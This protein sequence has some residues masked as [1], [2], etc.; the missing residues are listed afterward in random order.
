KPDPTRGIEPNENYAR[1]LLQ[2]FS[3]GTVKLNLDGTPQL[4]G[5][6]NPIPSYDQDV[7]EGFAHVFTGWTYPTQPNATPVKHNPTYYTGPMVLYP[8]NHDT[9]AKLLLNGVTLSA[10]QSGDADLNAAIDN[11]FNHPNVGSFI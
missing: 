10:G 8:S 3:I 7:V 1:E 9:G 5:M 11:I 4:D 6:G 2:L